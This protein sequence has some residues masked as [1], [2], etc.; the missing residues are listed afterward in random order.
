MA[1]AGVALPSLF[2]VSCRTLNVGEPHDRHVFVFFRNKLDFVPPP[3]GLPEFI[4][5]LAA[6][7]IILLLI[8]L[9]RFVT[10]PV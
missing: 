4:S 5:V 6:N 8:S 3:R 10:S 1:R 2:A 7:D 9:T